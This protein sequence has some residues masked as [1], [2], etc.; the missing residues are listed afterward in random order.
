MVT[1]KQNKTDSSERELLGSFEA[2]ADDDESSGC[3]SSGAARRFVGDGALVGGPSPL[4]SVSCFVRFVAGCS[5]CSAPTTAAAAPEDSSPAA[6]PEVSS[7][8][9][10]LDAPPLLLCLVF[11]LFLVFLI[12]LLFLVFLLFLL[13]LLLRLFLLRLRLRLLR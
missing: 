1:Y 13:R 9:D 8:S 7:G 10:S 12:F 5:S 4:V 3:S 2:G 11:L 6:A